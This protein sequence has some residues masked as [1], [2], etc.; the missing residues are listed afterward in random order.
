MPQIP[1]A[2]VPS[3]PPIDLDAD[4]RASGEESRE[5]APDVE[6]AV[7]KRTADARMLD[8]LLATADQTARA[9][10][11]DPDVGD[12]LVEEIRVKRTGFS[13]WLRPL[14]DDDVAEARERSRKRG[15]GTDPMTGRPRIDETEYRNRL[16]Y[17]A[18]VGPPGQKI[19]DQAAARLDVPPIMV[20]TL[21][22]P[23]V[24]LVG[25]RDQAYFRLLELSG[26]RSD[27]Q[28]VDE[29]KS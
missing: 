12:D 26:W 4:R 25:E 19:W 21:L 16:L 9:Y 23:R 18:T 15:L 6:P 24:L 20:H 17:A 11:G 10:R 5:I 3:R 7:A 22:S 29:A 14:T 13:F 28:L 2:R 8:L 27:D 1:V